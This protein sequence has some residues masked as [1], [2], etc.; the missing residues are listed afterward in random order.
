M[1]LWC[2]KIRHI[3]PIW[4]SIIL[5]ILEMVDTSVDIWE[6]TILKNKKRIHFPSIKARIGQLCRGNI[7]HILCDPWPK[8]HSRGFTD[9]N[10]CH[11]AFYVND[12]SNF[13]PMLCT[14]FVVKIELP[15]YI[16]SILIKHVMCISVKITHVDFTLIFMTVQV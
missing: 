10:F 3:N 7:G 5:T 9:I 6:E 12:R 2:W 16:C 8:V 4:N 15:F 14:L 13:A 1:T 11:M